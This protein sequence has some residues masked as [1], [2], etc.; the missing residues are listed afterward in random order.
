VAYESCCWSFRI[1]HFQE[2]KS[3][4]DDG[5]NYSTGFELVLSGLGSTSTPLKDRIE[6]T[7]PDYSANLRYKP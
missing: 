4:S 5:Y 1:A 7:I 2:D 3:E 6:N